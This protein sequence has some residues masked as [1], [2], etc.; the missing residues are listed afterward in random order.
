MRSQLQSQSEPL[1]ARSRPHGLTAFCILCALV[2]CGFKPV[3]E[4]LKDR[5]EQIQIEIHAMSERD[6]VR[7][8]ESFKIFVVAVPQKGW[9]F[10]SME[11]NGQDPTVA[12]RLVIDQS[13]FEVVGEWAETPP[14]LVKDEAL[15][16]WVKVHSHRAEFSRTLVA[17][18]ALEPGTHMVRGT[19]TYRICDNKVCAL[20]QDR[21]FQFHVIV[22][23]ED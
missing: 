23:T 15:G 20:P 6:I 21:P 5:A 19:L 11:A 17:P 22:K 18:E 2:F 7:P 4:F 8:G 9:H 13:P 12:T 3:Q 10:Y 16:R 1:H 14:T